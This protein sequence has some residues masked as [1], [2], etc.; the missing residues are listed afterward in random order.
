MF[1]MKPRC[2]ELA[3]LSLPAAGGAEYHISVQC[4]RCMSR[5]SAEGRGAWAGAGLGLASSL[6][7]LTPKLPPDA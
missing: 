2:P 1:C 3:L 4:V 6:E 5:G 7:E